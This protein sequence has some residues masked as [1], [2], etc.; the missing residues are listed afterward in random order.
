MSGNVRP[1]QG[2]DDVEQ[3][4]RRPE[5]PEAGPEVPPVGHPDGGS[6]TLRLERGEPGIESMVE[7]EVLD[8]SCRVEAPGALVHDCADVVDRGLQVLPRQEVLDDE[9][10]VVEVTVDFVPAERHGSTPVRLPSVPSA[11][12]ETASYAASWKP[13][14]STSVR[15]NASA[16]RC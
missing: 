10:A 16:S 7:V 11:A 1:D 15:W 12:P 3:L 9:K 2:L 6:R 14:S 13:I 5:L 4:R 8:T